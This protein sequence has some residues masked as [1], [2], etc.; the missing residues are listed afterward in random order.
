VV[1]VLDGLAD[2]ERLALEWKYLDNHSVIEIA[3]RLLAT[4][5]AVES[6]LYRGRREFRNRYES[7]ERHGSRAAVLFGNSCDPPN[8]TTSP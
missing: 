1:E 3:R 7:L 5:K 2:R 6:I 4:P 8:G